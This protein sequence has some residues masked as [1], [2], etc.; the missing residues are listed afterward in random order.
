M[1][2]PGH[3]DDYFSDDESDTSSEASDE[4]SIGFNDDSKWQKLRSWW[5]KKTNKS[6]IAGEDSSSDSDDDD[7]DEEISLFT[8]ARCR[9]NRVFGIL[10]DVFVGIEH[11]HQERYGPSFVKDCC[12][13]IKLRP[14]DRV[15]GIDNTQ[16]EL[17]MLINAADM[18]HKR[19]RAI[20]SMCVSYKA[21]M[22]QPV[23]RRINPDGNGH[24]EICIDQMDSVIE[25]EPDMEPTQK[26]GATLLDKRNMFSRGFSFVLALVYSAF[27]FAF[28]KGGEI[29]SRDPQSRHP[30]QAQELI[31]KVAMNEFNNWH[32]RGLEDGISRDSWLLL[33]MRP[34]PLPGVVQRSVNLETFLNRDRSTEQACAALTSAKKL[35]AV[36]KTWTLKARY[37][38]TVEYLGRIGT[39]VYLI[40]LL[41]VI[42]MELYQV[43]NA[44]GKISDKAVRHSMPYSDRGLLLRRALNK[45]EGAMATQQTTNSSTS[46]RDHMAKQV[47]A[48]G[49]I[50]I[51]RKAE[52]ILIRYDS[53]RRARELPGRRPLPSRCQSAPKKNT[54]T[55]S[56]HVCFRQTA[57]GLVVRRFCMTTKKTLVQMA[58]GGYDL[59]GLNAV[60]SFVRGK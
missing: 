49:V 22:D 43:H 34:H 2:I 42:N 8:T 20:R 15:P 1:R 5:S 21:R 53:W 50:H 9:L 30:G 10:N 16:W 19:L 11:I 33:T 41:R 38:Q 23:K 3:E 37:R 13:N 26:Q 39:C 44:F 25:L 4:S 6:C 54:I 59:R 52:S 35:E 56:S 31:S 46:R 58:F 24:D 28:K 36:S 12:G 55:F 14:R 29:E 45:R 40:K 18:M 47:M 60:S 32:V 7:D 51:E 48:K 57:A 27:C 17:M